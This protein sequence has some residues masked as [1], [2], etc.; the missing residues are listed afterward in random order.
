L[1]TGRESVF[2]LTPSFIVFMSLS[3]SN[4]VESGD[5]TKKDFIHKCLWQDSSQEHPQNCI[6][7]YKLLAQERLPSKGCLRQY[8]D[9]NSCNKPI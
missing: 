7:P 2:S 3:N 4:K 1:K 5:A 9:T 6:I 8:T